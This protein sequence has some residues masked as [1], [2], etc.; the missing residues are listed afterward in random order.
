MTND[1]SIQTVHGI[2]HSVIAPILSADTVAE[3]EP[4]EP[5]QYRDGAAKRLEEV[6]RKME[7]KTPSSQ[8]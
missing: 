1:T 8:D 4:P 3:G 6:Q 5:Q 2:S 7:S